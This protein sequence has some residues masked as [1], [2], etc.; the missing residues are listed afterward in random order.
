MFTIQLSALCLWC[1]CYQIIIGPILA[2]ASPITVEANQVALIPGREIVL[3]CN[4]TE[5]PELEFIWLRQR[6]YPKGEIAPPKNDPIVLNPHSEGEQHTGLEDQDFHQNQQHEQ[7]KPSTTSNNESGG[8]KIIVGHNA[9]V[10]RSPTYEDVG[11]YFCRV[12]GNIEL[13]EKEKRILV[14]AQPYI[15]DFQIESSTLLSASVEEG[16]PLKIPCN[17]EEDFE[18]DKNVRIEWRVSKFDDDMDSDEVVHGEDGIRIEHYNE[19]SQALVFDKVTKEHRKFYKCQVS[20]GITKN[21]KTIFIRVKNKHTAIWPT[22]GIVLEL[23]I[24]IGVI[25]VVENRKIEPDRVNYDRKA[26]QM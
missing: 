8:S 10:L 4:V 1:H 5:Y 12:K 15:H 23:L 6:I 26:I 11:D 7:I 21:S 24:L 19:T 9:I 20:N 18:P 2:F 16:K 22:V 3:R 25:C 17:V 13:L 14:R